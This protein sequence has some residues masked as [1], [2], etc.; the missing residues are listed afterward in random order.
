VIGTT[1][2]RAE[3]AVGEGEKIVYIDDNGVWSETAKDEERT[4]EGE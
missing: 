2:S 4:C 1:I 3:T